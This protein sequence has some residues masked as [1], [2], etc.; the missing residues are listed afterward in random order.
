MS[1]KSALPHPT[2]DSQYQHK[3]AVNM[4][5]SMLRGYLAHRDD[6]E[7]LVAKWSAAALTSGTLAGVFALNRQL[8]E[9]AAGATA[10]AFSVAA[11]VAIPR[12]GRPREPMSWLGLLVEKHLFPLGRER[13]HRIAAALAKE[14]LGEKH[15]TTAQIARMCRQ[16]PTRKQAVENSDVDLSTLTKGR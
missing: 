4:Q 12:P 16:S 1:P 5:C 14:V 2:K 15:V 3:A 11:G 7:D 13:C 8:G 9:R 6:A 10:V